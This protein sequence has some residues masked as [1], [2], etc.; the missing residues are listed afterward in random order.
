MDIIS[1]FTDN[2]PYEESKSLAT[3]YDC[4]LSIPNGPGIGNVLCYTSLVK[5]FALKHG[6]RLKILTAPLHPIV[7]RVDGDFEEYPIWKNNPYI[8]SIINCNEINTEIIKTINKQKDDSCQFS[9]VI[10]NICFA[11]NIFPEEIRPDLHLSYE[12]KVWALNFLNNFKRPIIAIH[13]FGKS[14]PQNRIKWYE[15]NWND[16]IKQYSNIS[17]IQLGMPGYEIK[18]IKALF[19]KLSLR[20]TF[21]IIWASDFFIGFDSSLGH[22]ATAFQKKTI[23][24]WNVY[25]KEDLERQKEI[26]FAGAMM[27]RW[28]YP[29][30]N[31]IML[32]GERKNETLYLCKKVIDK[33]IK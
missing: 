32:L 28:A 29:Q 8:K 22:V 19:P 12:E 5:N 33:W 6:K 20:Q 10:E 27:L 30:N 18:N 25:E 23:I 21:S 11:Y 3:K 16:L 17:F 14:S 4:D 24:L 7:G 1:R 13:P 31:N 2:S 15:N 26:G 9:H